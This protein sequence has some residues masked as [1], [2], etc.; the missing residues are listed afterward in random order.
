M[1]DLKFA[2][3]QLLKNPGF[4]T[5]AVLPLALGI[6]ANL[7]LFAILNELLLRPKPVANPDELWAIEPADS[8]GQ[9]FA[10]GMVFRPYYDAILQHARVFR[11][12]IGYAGIMPKLRTKEGAERIHAELVSGDYFSF[13]GVPMVLGRGFLPEEDAKPGTHSVAVISHAFWQGQFGS[14]ADVIGKTITLNDKVVE[15]VGVAPGEFHGLDF[16]QPALWMPTSMEKL[17]DEHTR[18]HFVGWLAE[19]KLVPAAVEMLAPVVAEVTSRGIIPGYEYYGCAPNF[20]GVRLEPIGRGSLGA[21]PK[22][23]ILGFLKFAGVATVLLLL[24]AC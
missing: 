5:V 13:L 19:P 9:P 18:Y 24:I 16:L 7:A 17:M 4:T 2:F 21:V 6:G 15:I 1:N 20:Q 10:H 22:E 3:R 12:V 8:A 11:G 14:A 23:G